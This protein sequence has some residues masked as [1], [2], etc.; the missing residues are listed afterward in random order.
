MKRALLL[1]VFGF[2]FASCQV[3]PKTPQPFSA[4]ARAVSSAKIDLPSP[5]KVFKPIETYVPPTIKKADSYT[6]IFL[7]DSM[8]DV[9]G[10][11]FDVLRKDLKEL[12]PNKIFGLFNY[13]F[14][15]TNILSVEKR[16]KSESKYLNKSFP[17]ILDRYSDIIIIE[18]FAYNPLSQFSIQEGIAKQNDALDHIVSEIV[19]SEPDTLIV[20]LA[21][22]APSKTKFGIGATNLTPADR[23]K[24]VSERVAY[25]ENHISYAKKHNIPLIN[26]YEKS[27]DKNGSGSLKYIDPNTH[28]H[29]SALGIKLISDSISNFLI[30]N[31][32]LPQ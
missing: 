26:V 13:G 30:D 5:T 1:I 4:I 11:N 32:V 10:E 6:I 29:P 25:L 21:T 14:G 18:S 31:S 3:N 12:Y 8:T 23:E 27:L 15:S 22:I 7:G 2:I 24:N 28:I 20:F 16:L 9:L 17:P 19:S